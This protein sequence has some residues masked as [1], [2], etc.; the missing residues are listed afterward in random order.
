MRK[1]E[2]KRQYWHMQDAKYEAQ[3]VRNAREHVEQNEHEAQGT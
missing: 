1:R 3:G 2:Q